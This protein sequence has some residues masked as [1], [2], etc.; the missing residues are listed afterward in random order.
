MSIHHLTIY[1]KISTGGD[2][3][4]GIFN[5]YIPNIPFYDLDLKLKISDQLFSE[6]SSEC[7]ESDSEVVFL[8]EGLYSVRSSYIFQMVFIVLSI[9][10]VYLN[11]YIQ[12]YLYI[13]I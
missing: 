10:Q 8:R 3:F 6:F 9:F 2:F 13:N 4:V 12:I 11:I 5:K 1:E 7:L